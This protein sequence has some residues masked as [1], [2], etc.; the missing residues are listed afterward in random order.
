MENEIVMD[1]CDCEYLETVYFEWDTGYRECE[2]GCFGDGIYDEIC[3]FN[4]KYIVEE[5]M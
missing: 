5:K 1:C 3:P 4:C 2:C